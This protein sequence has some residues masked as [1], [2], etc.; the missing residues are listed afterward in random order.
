MLYCACHGQSK[1]I[2]CTMVR[3][4]PSQAVVL[5]LMGCIV[6]MWPSMFGLCVCVCVCVCVCQR[7]TKDRADR[8]SV[9]VCMCVCARMC[10]VPVCVC[11]VMK[12]ADAGRLESKGLV[13]KLNKGDSQMI[14]NETFCFSCM[15]SMTSLI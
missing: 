4:V 14:S 8:E 5:F 7:K 6:S 10:V 9:C 2:F 11:L 13:N 15:L 3:F 12:K 1:S